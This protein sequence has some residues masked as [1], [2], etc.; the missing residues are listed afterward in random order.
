MRQ[1]RR[2][3]RHGRGDA[4][5]A[6][7]RGG[8]EGRGELLDVPLLRRLTEAH[9]DGPVVDGPHEVPRLRELSDDHPGIVDPHRNGVEERVVHHRPAGGADG[10]GEVAGQTVHAFRDG[11]QPRGPVV[12]G[13]HAGGDRQQRLRGA[14]VRRRPFPADV[15]LPGLQ[16]HAQRPAATAVHRYPDDAPGHGPLVLIPSRKEGGVGAAVA[17]GDTETLGGAEHHVRAQFP[18]RGQQ[19]QAQ[20]VGRH[21]RQALLRLD[22]LDQ[23]PQIADLAPG[24]GVLQ[25]RT[26]YRMVLQLRDVPDDQLETEGLGPG[27]HHRDGLR[28]T[29]LVDEEGIA[30]TARHPPRQGH[31]L[32]GSGGLVQQRGVG[33]LHPGQVQGQLLEVEQRLQ[34]ALGDL[35]LIGGVGGIPARILQHVAQYHRRQ[36]G[37]VIPHADAGGEQLIARSHLAQAGQHIGLAARAGQFQGT[38]QAYA[39]RYRLVD[40]LIQ[41]TQAQGLQHAA[42]LLGVRTYVPPDE[43]I[44]LLQLGKTPGG[45]HTLTSYQSGPDPVPLRPEAPHQRLARYPSASSSLSSSLLSVGLILKNQASP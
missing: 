25:H 22:L 7:R 26:E 30:R 31:G 17:H 29:V 5:G 24:G 45:V 39:A 43:G 4:A 41:R 10:R 11:P 44:L 28:V 15:L 16:R 33:Q 8:T 27:A 40:Q 35:R 34:P 14:D 12:D 2:L 18:G 42:L 19:Y 3:P 1:R 9:A 37:V 36:D 23:W 21:A 38:V 20:G 32:G 6:R 13:V